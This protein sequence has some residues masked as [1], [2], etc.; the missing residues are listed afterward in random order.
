MEFLVLGPLEVRRGGA[1]V[2][3]TAPRQRA[4]LALLLLS[5]NRVIPAAS[6][7]D[8]LWAGAPPATA[9]TTL[10]TLVYRLRRILQPHGA[11]GAGVRTRAS[12]YVLEVP[13]GSV[14]R[15]RF[16]H[17][18]AEGMTALRTGD[19]A[20]GVE[21]LRR[22]LVL[23]RGPA[24]ADIDLPAIRAEAS[25][26]DG[27]RL[28]TLEACLRAE[29]DLDRCEE[30]IGELEQHV[31]AY[32]LRE[33]ACATLIRALCASGR[34][35]DALAA[36]AT[37][38]R[39]LVEELGIEPCAELQ[40][41]HQ[42]ILTGT[43]EPRGPAAVA[44]DHR[45]ALPAQLPANVPAFTGRTPELRRLDRLAAERGAMVVIAVAGTAGVGKT[46]LAVHWAQRNRDRF[47]DGQLHVN[48]RG[49]DPA[50]SPVHPAEALH[51]FLV[52]LG[53]PPARIPSSVDDRAALFR[54]LLADRRMLVLVDNARDAD[55]VRPLLPGSS[56]CLVVVTS[57][58][59]LT[60]LVAGDGA[61]P[62]TLDVLSIEEA[63]VMLARRLGADRVAAE[64]HAVEE[65][66]TQCARLP[67]ALA[68][69]A[70]RAATRPEFPLAALAGQLRDAAGLDAFTSAEAA[71][72]VRSVLS[73]SY[74]ALGEEASHLFRLLGVHPGPDVATTAAASLAGV[75][76]GRVRPLLAELTRAHLLAEH[77]PGRFAFHDL[78][79]AYAGTLANTVERDA[80]LHRVLDHGLHTAH[81]A[82]LLLDPHRDPIIPAPPQPGVRP[83][84][85]DNLDQALAWFTAEHAVLLAA[86]ELAGSTGFDTHA[87]QLAW[88]LADF[89]DRGGHYR[90][91]AATQRLA[92]RAAQRLADLSAQAAAHHGLGRAG[93]GHGQYRDAHNHFDR[94]A[95][96]FAELG[97]HTGQAHTELNRTWVLSLQN[98]DAEALHHAE[99]VLDRF[100][101]AG[102]RVGSANTL[103]AIGWYHTQL[104]NHHE[105]VRHCQRALAL[106]EDLDD[107]TGQANTLDSLGVAHHHLGH[108]RQ[109]IACYHRALDQY[110]NLGDRYGEADTLTHLGQTHHDAG[111][112]EAGRAAWQRALTIL[113][114]LGHPNAQHVR[115]QLDRLHHSG[116]PPHGHP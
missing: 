87:W 52:A 82:A 46:A 30:A 45:P 15:P 26:L 43:A 108:H 5:P 12:G 38:R 84:Q 114:E 88:T 104:G 19:P 53:V 36:Y 51:G 27:S 42:T 40:R 31:R 96:L 90:D 22:A 62:V 57:R 63:R 71:T 4:V 16:D 1:L 65:I 56:G 111:D 85:V 29:V 76:I 67:L 80:A 69:V 23:W 98:R 66:I 102:H 25:R 44:V 92:L 89:L 68:I 97:D 109:A 75:P 55:Q 33:Q 91:L 3:V 49:F 94:A 59:E 7:V 37:A 6:L 70:A 60:G 99:R 72:D 50:G 11:D 61:H 17:L 107:R 10:H 39:H 13:E 93:V 103:N 100:H 21:L 86:V 116:T 83:G 54:S 48:L 2:E 113:D 8:A 9:L 47:S 73:W 41:L 112:P 34:Q 20:A 110:R 58:H 14:D 95:A 32:P 77:S 101:A 106:L 64:P 78:L 79:R 115:T 28:T 18:A 24:F 105:A 81:R 35:A 74:R